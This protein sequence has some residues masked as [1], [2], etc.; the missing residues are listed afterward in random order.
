MPPTVAQSK[1]REKERRRLCVSVIGIVVLI[2][3]VIAALE[4][5]RW[6]NYLAYEPAEG[7]VIFQSLPRGKLVDAIEG[8]THSPW[9]H[10]GIVAR[11]EQGRWIVYEALNGVEATPLRQFL[12][13]SRDDRYAIYRWQDRYQSQMPAVLKQ[14]RSHLGKPYDIRYRMENDE[15]YCSELIYQAFR[16]ATGEEPGKLVALGEL[17]WGPYRQLIE[18]LEGGAAP[19]ER[20]MITPRDLAAA[21]QLSR[22]HQGP[23]MKP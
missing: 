22:I 13:R 6:T 8:A 14:V 3:I 23:G 18:H 21:T 5:P 20:L 9:S 15:I 12:W 19:L 11:D 2:V 7:D 10:C 4:G 1:H 17:D 16:D